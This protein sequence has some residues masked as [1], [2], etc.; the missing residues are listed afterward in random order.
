[1]SQP[2]IVSYYWTPECCPRVYSLLIARLTIDV[3]LLR[4]DG[5]LCALGPMPEGAQWGSELGGGCA[6]VLVAT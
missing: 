1:M 4:L 2:L 6:G 3:Q 5:L